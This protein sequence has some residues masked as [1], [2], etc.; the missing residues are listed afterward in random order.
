VEHRPCSE[1]VSWTGVDVA[2]PRVA[3]RH[4]R[5][6][7]F[8]CST[9]HPRSPQFPAGGCCFGSALRQ[10]AGGWAEP[11]PV[12]VRRRPERSREPRMVT[13]SAASSRRSASPVTNSPSS[14]STT[15]DMRRKACLRS[16]DRRGSSVGAGVR[17]RLLRSCRPLQRMPR[18]GSSARR[19]KG[20]TESPRRPIDPFGVRSR[21]RPQG[22]LA[23]RASPP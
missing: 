19:R 5:G 15:T 22:D 11:L 3:G 2:G 13:S 18:L 9:P 23:G 4:A 12:P 21:G 1:G 8:E 20:H 14:G 16:G 7:R 17:P 10:P 6:Q